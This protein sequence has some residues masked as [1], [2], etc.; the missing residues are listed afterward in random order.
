[1][2]CRICFEGDDEYPLFEPC[3]CTGSVAH[4]HE[5]CLF[6]WVDTKDHKFPKCELCKTRYRIIYNRPVE[7]IDKLSLV[8]GYFL[9]YPSWHTMA[10]CV[11]QIILTKLQPWYSMEVNYVFAQFLY[12][13][14]YAFISVGLLYRSLRSPV[15]YLRYAISEH[16]CRVLI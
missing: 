16:R 7:A 3:K 13:F 12:Q 10:A 9:V 5:H 4:I 8:H 14:A 15:T 1:M 2:I 6:R 11:L